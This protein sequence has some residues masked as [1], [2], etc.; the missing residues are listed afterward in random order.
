MWGRHVL[1]GPFLLFA[2]LALAGSAQAQTRCV[3]GKPCDSTCIAKNETCRAGT[4]SARSATPSTPA[5]PATA[6]AIPDGAE[7]VASSRGRVYY[8]V[9]CSAWQRLARSNLIFFESAEDALRAG[10]TPS[11]ASGCAGPAGAAA[12]PAVAATEVAP[13]LAALPVCTVERV[14]DGDTLVCGEGERIR[15]LLIDTPELSQGEIGATAKQALFELLPAGTEARIELD[16]QERDR[17]GRVLAYVYH[18]DGR[19][20]NEELLRAGFAVVS[21]YPPNVKYVDRFRAAAQ[22]A[23]DGGRGF[24]ATAA[25]ACLPAEHR[26]GRCE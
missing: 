21:V 25:F 17:Y 16:V 23:R 9:G 4:G 11:T 7:Y 20:V 10:Y 5:T 19:L 8:W 3:T 12:A 1:F 15:L 26:A 24:W 6:A 18:P 14:I 22:A 13:E 2:L